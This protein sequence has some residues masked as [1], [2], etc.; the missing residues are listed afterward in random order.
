MFEQK[1]LCGYGAY[2]ARWEQLRDGDQQVH[3]KD[4][5][6]AHGANGTITTST[7]KT[8]RRRRI[9]SHYEFAS[10]R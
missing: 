9:A 5:E 3:G 7:C 10:H 2:A 4:E 1:R 6:F 8:A